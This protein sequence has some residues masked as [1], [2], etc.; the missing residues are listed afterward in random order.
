MQFDFLQILQRVQGSVVGR[1][2]EMAMILSAIRVQRPILLIGVP[3]V[4]KTTILRALMKEI[5]GEHRLYTATGD[6]QLS[7]HGLVGTFDPS[8]VMKDGY[9]LE[10]FV[11][12]PLTKAMQT[13]GMFYLEELN[14]TPSNTLNVLMTALSDRY[15]DVPH[16]GRV[17]A[18][19]GFSFVASSNPLDDIGTDRLSR[20]LADRF[21]TLE[22]SYQAE[23][24]EQDIV[25]QLAPD[26]SKDWIAYAV[27][28]ARLSRRHSDLLY[29]ASIRGSIDFLL[30]LRGLS[31]VFDAP[32]LMEV[33][34]AAFAG[35]VSVRPSVDRTARNIILEIMQ[36]LDTPPPD[37]LKEMWNE[38][39][40]SPANGS[41]GG[42]L[43]TAGETEA[44][45]IAG[46]AVQGEQTKETRIDLAWQ[47][48]G[49]GGT[50]GPSRRKSEQANHLQFGTTQEVERLS[51]RRP[52]HWIEKDVLQQWVRASFTQLRG[53]QYSTSGIPNGRLQTV[54]LWMDPV[55]EMDIPATVANLAAGLAVSSSLMVR[56]R[57]RLTRRFA[58]FVDHSGSMIGSK[59][60]IS[61]ALASVLT[62]LSAAQ[63]LRLGVYAFDQG[64]Q[65]IK[66]LSEA[67]SSN[68][69]IDEILRLSEGRSTDIGGVFRF[70]AK[71]LER[72]PDCEVIVVSDCMPTRGEKT[73]LA[74]ESLAQKIPK[75]YILQVSGTA[76]RDFTLHSPAG[77]ESLDLYGLW[78][79]RW[80]GPERFRT[81]TGIHDLP[82]AVQM[83]TRPA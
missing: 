81:L 25:T 49:A 76:G 44:S 1:K 41:Q 20:G 33:G 60:M 40:D 57:S 12:G 9:K 77:M 82:D 45:S 47:D 83:I 65:P 30:M 13:G 50:K 6:E 53:G 62:K 56:T 66:E 22:L 29:G 2:T 23:D 39:G 61:A 4:S 15:L 73:F 72:W 11:P 42:A 27:Q 68:R 71:L 26:F 78:A 7:V 80:A 52:S 63:H 74:L 36:H 32:M 10:Y 17:E 21:I 43:V 19:E 54:P 3:G 58:M 18:K 16:F 38:S 46:G 34:V 75:L 55:A 48:S 64:I 37:K 35:R 70:S 79:M 28:I 5:H 24:E 59:L 51:E 14:R 67:K 8:L 31:A 69:V